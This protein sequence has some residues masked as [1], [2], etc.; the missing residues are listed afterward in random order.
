MRLNEQ[1][2]Q[3]LVSY[4]AGKLN[5]PLPVFRRENRMKWSAT[6]THCEDCEVFNFNYNFNIIKSYT[7][8]AIAGVIFHELGHIKYKSYKSRNRVKNEFMAE[9]FSLGCLK[10]YYPDFY[11]EEIKE[12][13]ELLKDKKW[14]KKDPIHA[15]AFDKIKEYK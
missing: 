2:F 8:S 6:I 7:H 4:W 12:G 1:N 3:N 11:K 13:K 10:K 15:K 5:L 9:K 14:I